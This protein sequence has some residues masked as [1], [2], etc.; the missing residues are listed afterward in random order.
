MTE[1]IV[2]LVG[3]IIALAIGFFLGRQ[4]GTAAT[5]EDDTKNLVEENKQ[6]KDKY[7]AVCSKLK[8]TE[9]GLENVQKTK[10]IESKY[11]EL[12]SEAKAECK[13]LDEQL[14][15]AISAIAMKLLKLNLMRS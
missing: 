15:N 11:K 8:D 13:K 6:L 2:L 7:S 3:V 9:A 14:K 4:K 1:W 10:D 12:L 5:V